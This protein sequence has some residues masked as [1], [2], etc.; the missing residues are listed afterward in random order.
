MGIWWSKLLWYNCIQYL[1]LYLSITLLEGPISGYVHMSA[2]AGKEHVIY[3]PFPL[4]EEYLFL[5]TYLYY[6]LFQGLDSI[7]MQLTQ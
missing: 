4:I 6:L 7:V 5:F 1:L 2:V 3:N